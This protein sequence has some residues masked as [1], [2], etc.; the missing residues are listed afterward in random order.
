M[1]LPSSPQTQ[2]STM[3]LLDK[4]I[5]RRVRITATL[6][7]A[8]H[9]NDPRVNKIQLLDVKIE[10]IARSEKI[11]HHVLSGKWESAWKQQDIQS[12]I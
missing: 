3:T 11:S 9:S 12:S 5:A 7:W 2:E 10:Q 4:L 6:P 1:A 8:P